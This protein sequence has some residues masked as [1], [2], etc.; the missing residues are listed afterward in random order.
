MTEGESFLSVAAIPLL[1]FAV[2][3]YYAFRL[4]VLHDTDCIRQKSDTKELKDKEAYTRTA[5]ELILFLAVGSLVMLG[6]WF[7]NTV[8]A[9]V[10][11]VIWIVIFGLLW[12]QMDRNYGAK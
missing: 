11:I 5:G 8:A 10:L 4:L 12:A 2:L 7:V 1:L 3:L 9:V 6:V